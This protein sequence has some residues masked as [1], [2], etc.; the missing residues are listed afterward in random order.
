MCTSPL[1][2]VNSVTLAGF[3]GDR[4]RYSLLLLAVFVSEEIFPLLRDNLY[5]RERGEE[6]HRYTQGGFSTQKFV[7][8]FSAI[9]FSH[10]GNVFGSGLFATAD[11]PRDEPS[12]ERKSKHVEI[13][14]KLVCN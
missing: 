13:S 5:R 9:N 7:E 10:E 12:E 3:S 4:A 1:A 2:R 14:C 11:E 8:F 6:L